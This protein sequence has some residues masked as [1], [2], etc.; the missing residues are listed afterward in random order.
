[1]AAGGPE[2]LAISAG[3]LIAGVGL[4]G[5]RVF[6]EL[7]SGA[8]VSWRLTGSQPQPR[9][10]NRVPAFAGGASA[11]SADGTLAVQPFG[12]RATQGP[13]HV[14]VITTRT[15]RVSYVAPAIPVFSIAA[16]SRDDT[17]LIQLGGS[18]GA[19]VG[20]AGGGSDGE[21]SALG[22]AGAVALRAPPGPPGG[23]LGCNWVD[24]A[25][26]RDDTLV[27]GA[28]FCGG[29]T[30][31]DAQ[32]GQVKATM[33]NPGEVSRIALS[34]DGGELAV[35]SWDS[36]ITIWRLLTRRPV[37]VLHG[38]TLG[39]D[40]VTYSPDGKLLA[41]AGLDDTARV[42]NTA[43]GRLLRIWTDPDPVTSIA[44]SSAGSELVTGDAGANVRVW[45]ACT[46]CG[47]A[48]ELLAIGRAS[49]TRQ[50]TP[51]ERATFV[52]GA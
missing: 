15:G 2:R 23:V 24:A 11:V 5:D 18:T 3:G 16:V 19:G 25:M 43:D 33:R 44:F 42:W 8:T 36:T 22:G 34:P 27:A 41:S 47:Q 30:V 50:L 46:A 21:V 6:A 39:V 12:P 10:R 29:I 13:T 4:V 40:A 26:S 38:H 49:V 20:P 31:W 48:Q 51:L 32:T 1:M 37:V 52:N 14:A 17:R 7:A 28:D 35:A 45:D 9:V